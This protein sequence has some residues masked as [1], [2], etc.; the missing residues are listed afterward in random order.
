MSQAVYW[1][2]DELSFS[3]NKN[4]FTAKTPWLSLDLP[5]D[6]SNQ[7][8]FESLAEKSGQFNQDDLG[9]LNQFLQLTHQYPIAY[10]LPSIK[11]EAQTDIH[12]V[13]KPNI[14]SLA[15]P[16]LLE[17]IVGSGDQDLFDQVMKVIDRNEWEWDTSN[18][19]GFAAIDNGI[20]PESLHSVARRFH[21][22]E[23]LEQDRG[24]EV[25]AHINKL[26][27]SEFHQAASVIVRQNHF[28]TQKCQQALKPALDIAQSAKATVNEFIQEENGHDRILGV[29]LKSIVDEPENVPVTPSTQALMMCL[30]YAASRNLLAFAMCVDFFERSSYEDM[31]P[32]AQLLARGGL[33]KAAKQINR[34]MEINDAGEHENVAASFLQWMA[35]CSQDYGLEALRLAELTSI[36]M[37]SVTR[38]CQPY[39]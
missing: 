3:I 5:I 37:C 9:L 25:F 23:V 28:V 39:I 30:E 21:L 29:A 19:L 11:H 17:E 34:H 15:L 13:Q 18:A 26:E 14:H 35:P 31:D 2:Y 27:G 7:A 33:D 1:P 36:L 10:T 16:K 4:S 8:Y 24:N 22:L 20:D 38:S 6:P 12:E 32:L